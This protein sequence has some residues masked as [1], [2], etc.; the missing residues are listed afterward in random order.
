MS[1]WGV[2]AVVL[3][4]LWASGFWLL[5]RIPLCGSARRGED[6]RSGGRSDRFGIVHEDCGVRSNHDSQG[7]S[8]SVVIPARNEAKN[9]PTLLRSLKAQSSRPMETIVVDD[10]STDATVPIAHD[11]GAAVIA[12][13]DLPSGWLGKTWACWQGAQIARG[14][15]LVFLDADTSLDPKGLDR[16]VQTYLEHGGLVSLW[17]FHR[18]RR[19]YERLSAFLHIIIMASMNVF[20][21]LGERLKP[22]GAFGPC[23]V[24]SRA[25]YFAVDGHR[26]VKGSILDDIALGVRFLKRGI[27]VHL[28]GGRGVIAFRMYP[29]GIRS[30]V[31]G[32]GKN[33]GSGFRIAS[34]VPLVLSFGWL[35]GAFVISYYLALSLLEANFTGALIWFAADLMYAT[36]IHWMLS[37]IGNFGFYTALF[38]QLPL[39]FFACVFSHSIISTFLWRRVQWKGRRI[40]LENNSEAVNIATIESETT[41]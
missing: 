34:L 12:S 17:P 5:W 24:C 35:T 30:I 10:G 20:S 3:S 38:F 6:L 21:P 25:H 18:M 4:A 19:L 32:F 14:E 28:F 39:F 37:R 27:G 36:Q 16:I 8:V 22:L 11:Y 7:P 2:I 33:M 29:D 1:E 41:D 26:G 31:T 40:R 9:L 15:I 23:L 13:Q